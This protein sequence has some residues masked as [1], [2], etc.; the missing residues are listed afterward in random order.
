MRTGSAQRSTEVRVLPSVSEK[1][2]SEDVHLQAGQ[3]LGFGL[4]LP[5]GGN[6]AEMPNQ[7]GWLAPICPL[8][9]EQTPASLWRLY[10]MYLDSQFATHI[11]FLYLNS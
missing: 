7:G 10:F 8:F 1:P 6:P 4:Y 11:D 2:A 5:F 9:T 3:P